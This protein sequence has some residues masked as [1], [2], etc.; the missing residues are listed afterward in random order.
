MRNFSSRFLHFFFFTFFLYATHRTVYRTRCQE[1]NRNGGREGRENRKERRRDDEAGTN[2]LRQPLTRKHLTLFFS[3]TSPKNERSSERPR[4][5]RK[6]VKSF[7]YDHPNKRLSYRRK[8]HMGFTSAW[9]SSISH[10]RG[11][12]KHQSLKDI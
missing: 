4:L 5:S 1:E 2:G 12:N 11:P 6:C 7:R 9:R 10:N 3:E 8:M